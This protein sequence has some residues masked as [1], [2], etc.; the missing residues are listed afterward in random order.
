MQQP[1]IKK[2]KRKKKKS[3][4][5]SKI[6]EFFTSDIFSYGDICPIHICCLQKL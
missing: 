5:I 4:E 2:K 6:K 1:L 3:C